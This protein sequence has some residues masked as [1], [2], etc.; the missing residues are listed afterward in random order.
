VCVLFIV[1]EVVSILRKAAGIIN[2]SNSSQVESSVT[3]MLQRQTS[4][5]LNSICHAVLRKHTRS[6][7][8]KLSVFATS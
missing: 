7:Y 4:I 8:M 6:A 5:S 3:E 1:C 2:L